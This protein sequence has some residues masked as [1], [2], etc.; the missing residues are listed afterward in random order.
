MGPD[1]LARI[2]VVGAPVL[3]GPCRRMRPID[4]PGLV[5]GGC[6][7]NVS[8]KMSIEYFDKFGLIWRDPCIERRNPAS[9]M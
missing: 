3:R 7:I 2:D 5:V 6:D 8:T 1:V 4:A 9:A